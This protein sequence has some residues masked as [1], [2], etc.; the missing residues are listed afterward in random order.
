[1]EG[2]TTLIRM[3]AIPRPD[4]L[5]GWRLIFLAAFV[6]IVACSCLIGVHGTRWAFS[7]AQLTH[8]EGPPLS[9]DE[10]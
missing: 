2:A 1:M 6:L 10:L 9:H 7:K 8:D 5:R 4:P 3:R